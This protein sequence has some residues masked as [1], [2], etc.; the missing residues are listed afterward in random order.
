[1]DEKMIAVEINGCKKRFPES[2]IPKV[3]AHMEKL[4]QEYLSKGARKNLVEQVCS[5][6]IMKEKE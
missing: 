6:R 2:Q 3:I 1:M 5:V 4:K